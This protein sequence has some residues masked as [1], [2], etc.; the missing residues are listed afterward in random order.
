MEKFRIFILHPEEKLAKRVADH[1][2]GQV[3]DCVINT[4]KDGDPFL[5]FNTIKFRKIK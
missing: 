3:A 2:P 1:F 4:F 5:G